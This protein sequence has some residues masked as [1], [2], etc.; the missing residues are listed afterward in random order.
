M[1][2][3]KKFF[4]DYVMPINFDVNAGGKSL[5]D[6]RKGVRKRFEDKRKHRRGMKEM[7]IGIQR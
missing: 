7:I 3:K 4:F 5:Y 6:L 2:R 1:E